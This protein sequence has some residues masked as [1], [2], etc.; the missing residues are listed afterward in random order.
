MMWVI[1]FG[2]GGCEGRLGSEYG[3]GHGPPNWFYSM[4]VWGRG[5]Y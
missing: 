4:S 1:G 2:V 3:V 5:G